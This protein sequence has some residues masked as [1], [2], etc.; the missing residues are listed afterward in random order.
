MRRVAVIVL[1]AVLL[2]STG[3]IGN[4]YASPPATRFDAIDV[5]VDSGTQPLAAYQLHL[6]AKT[7]EVK[8]VGI[9]GGEHSAFADPPYYDPAAMQHDRVIIA[10]FNTAL[11]EQ[12]PKGVTRVATIHV[13]VAGEAQPTFQAE[14]TVAATLDG[15]TIPA[16]LVLQ[17]GA[18]Q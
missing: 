3:R 16:H 10:A 5:Y 13:Q 1:V 14:L 2:G 9:E 4:R 8:I 11:P 15:K 17:T 12:L 7:G 6:S 18:G